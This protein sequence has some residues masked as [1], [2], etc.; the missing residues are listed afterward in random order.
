MTDRTTARLVAQIE[1]L[2][3]QVTRQADNYTRLRRRHLAAQRQIAG[4][5]LKVASLAE[6]VTPKRQKGQ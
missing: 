1:Q 5:R 3:D 2:Q 6:Q 4:L